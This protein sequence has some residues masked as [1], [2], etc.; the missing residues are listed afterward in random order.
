MPLFKPRSLFLAPMEDITD[1]PFRKLCRRY[2]AEVTISEFISSDGLIRDAEK[3]RRKM[4][5]S[6]DE[7]PVGIQIFGGNIETVVE[8]ALIA[9]SAAPDFID[10]NFGC[11]VKAVVSK[12]GGAALLQDIPKMIAMTKA[13]VAAVKIPVT[14]KTRLG[15]SENDKPVVGVAEKLQDAGIA[16]ISIHGRTRAQMY[17]GNSDW[18]LIRAVK[19]N[20]RMHI[21]VIGNGDIDHPVKAGEFFDKY[22]VDGLM[23]GRAATGNP[24][25]FRTIRHFLD[26]GGVLLPPAVPER[27]GVC[28]SLLNDLCGFYN[29]S[30]GLLR[31]RKHYAGIFRGLPDFKKFRIRLVRAVSVSEILD[32]TDGILK[33][34]APLNI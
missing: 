28:Q 15:W 5:I 24:W 17:R 31:M 16:A 34:Y 14:A 9:E 26:T 11:P 2:G 23:I 29:E 21:P 30:A 4:L 13:V 10:L 18:S 1:P 22:G 3:S 19:E 32:I 33:E 25:I 6:P 27:V 7:K 8:A 20:P 12:G